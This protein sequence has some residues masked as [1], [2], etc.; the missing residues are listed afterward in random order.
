MMPANPR[1][2]LLGP[3]GG[4]KSSVGRLLAERLKSSFLD[5][6]D[7][8]KRQS[9]RRIAELFADVGD[10]GFRELE[11]A[12]LRQALA[13]DVGV[14]ATGGGVV[15]RAPNRELLR[16]SQAMRVL[17]IAPPEILWHRVRADPDTLESRPSLTRMHG[18]AEIRHVLQQRLPFYEQVATHTIDTSLHTAAEVVDE[19]IHAIQRHVGA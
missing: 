5:L 3:R 19:I 6:D 7:E 9:G 17:L 8:I 18:E 11:S 12:A 15:L 1:I 16:N 10:P 2:I 14:I 13:S 4:G